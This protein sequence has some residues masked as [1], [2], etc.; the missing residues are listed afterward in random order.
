[1]K[2]GLGLSTASTSGLV[3]LGANGSELGA[4]WASHPEIV[5]SGLD[6]VKA[7][8]AKL[9]YAKS[10]Y[11]T[12]L[13]LQGFIFNGFSFPR[14]FIWFL[15]D[16]SFDFCRLSLDFRR[17]SLDFLLF[18][19][20]RRFSLSEDFLFGFMA[21]ID[22]GLL[23][24]LQSTYWLKATHRNHFWPTTLQVWS[25]ARMRDCTKIVPRYQ[26]SSMAHEM[27]QKT[28]NN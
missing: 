8:Y 2:S 19:L 11:I 16:F 17:Q 15:F 18:S 20:D 10:R 4:F 14:I 9:K 5:F 26:K 25:P 7:K 28:N 23:R 13:I 27:G 22:R 24:Y 3:T 12:V 1:M 6:F 21:D